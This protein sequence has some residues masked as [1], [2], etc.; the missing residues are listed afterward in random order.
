M[1][2]AITDIF[3]PAPSGVGPNPPPSGSWL[4]TILNNAATIGLTTSAWQAGGI[5]R[6]IFAITSNML[7]LEDVNA[8]IM[9]QGG[10]LDF[11]ATGTVTFVD[12]FTGGSITRYV[13]PDPSAPATWPTSSVPFAGWLDILADSVYNVQ[14]IQATNAA[15]TI[16]FTNTS[17]SGTGTFQPGTFHVSNPAT[18]A[19]Y[20]NTVAFSI[21]VG[22]SSTTFAADVA[23]TGSNSAA[24]TITNLITSVVG[25]TCT[26][27]SAFNAGNYESNTALAAR[28]RLKVQAISSNGPKGA[29]QF[30][31]LTAQQIL[32]TATGLASPLTSTIAQANTVPNTTNGTVVT[33]VAPQNP[34]NGSVNGAVVVQGVAGLAITNA[35]NA[36]PIVVTVGSTTGMANNMIVNITGVQGNGAANG[37]WQVASLTGTTFALL[38]PT[39]GAN[40]AGNGAYTTGGIV[41]AGDLGL[42]D[43]VLQANCV[44]LAV[45]ATT[46]S[47]IAQWVVVNCTVYVPAAQSAGVKSAIDTALGNYFAAVPIGGFASGVPTPNTL[48]F[49]EV[50]AVISN[51][52]PAIRDVTLTLN[53]GT[54]DVA[55]TAGNVAVLVYP[56]TAAI[57]RSINDGGINLVTF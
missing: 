36:S 5:A 49:G 16:T 29:Y 27:P 19:T 45:T 3:T 55:I 2:L 12:P 42:V 13:T 33:T 4:A 9:A 38:N 18:G 54:A 1:T 43:S 40:S 22:T 41:E 39:T 32:Q 48:P 31:A 44:P 30:F 50:L 53:G 57:P 52:S 21:P 25:V 47:A 51:A 14:R 23:G 34:P 35:T 37:Y 15:G 7:A 6:T 28:C 20:S 46:V 17:G 8:S 56:A 11:A 24:G 10:F 26:N